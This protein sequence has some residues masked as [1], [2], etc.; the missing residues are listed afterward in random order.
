MPFFS[1]PDP[2]EKA[3]L[4]LDTKLKAKRAS[5]D[6][7]IAR[8][9]AAEAAAAKYRATPCTAHLTGAC[10][11]ASRVTTRKARPHCP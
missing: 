11:L 6:D 3:Q 9:T 10:R 2:A 8:R 1:K 5:R 4:D 7:L